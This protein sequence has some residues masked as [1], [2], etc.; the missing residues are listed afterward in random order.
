M[1]NQC[2]RSQHSLQ[3]FVS[4]E[5][6]VILPYL[7]YET[8]QK[9]VFSLKSTT[10]KDDHLKMFVVIKQQILVLDGQRSNDQIHCGDG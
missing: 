3:S 6:T 5:A 7:G 10:V 8:K 1:S 2:F 9:K 4:D